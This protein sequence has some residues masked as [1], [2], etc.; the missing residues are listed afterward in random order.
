MEKQRSDKSGEPCRREASAL[1]DLLFCVRILGIDYRINFSDVRLQ[2]GSD[3]IGNVDNQACV[4]TVDSRL[5]SAPQASSVLLHKIIE[6][7]AYRLELDLK[8]AHIT[9]L[10]AGLMQVIRDNPKL[11]PCLAK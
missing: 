4:I 5:N 6:V 11:L 3:E 1:N 9:Q 2:N 8:H 7:L 10:E